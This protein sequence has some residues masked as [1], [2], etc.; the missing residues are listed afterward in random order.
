MGIL[1]ISR[2][3]WNAK[4]VR[5]TKFPIEEG[6]DPEI[7]TEFT[8]PISILLI[9]PVESH[10][11]PL[12]VVVAPEQ[13]WVVLGIPLLQAHAYGLLLISVAAT[14]SQKTESETDGE[15]ISQNIFLLQD[16]FGTH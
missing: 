14:I 6:S 2:L 12:Q 3:S 10:M 9:L 8:G 15:K 7:T 16:L 1:P 5:D 11:I 13:T 4:D